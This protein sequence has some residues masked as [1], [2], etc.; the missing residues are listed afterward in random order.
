[1]E[2]DTAHDQSDS[3]ELDRCSQGD[4]IGECASTQPVSNHLH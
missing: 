4:G 2:S 1:M 3:N